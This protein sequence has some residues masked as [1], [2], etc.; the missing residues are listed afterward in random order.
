MSNVTHA[1]RSDSFQILPFI[2]T[3]SSGWFAIKIC[4]IC[5]GFGDCCCGQRGKIVVVFVGFS[6]CDFSTM[7]WAVD[8]IVFNACFAVADTLVKFI[9]YTGTSNGLESKTNS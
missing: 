8:A 3:E 2:L 1:G 4:G 5:S 6:C 9:S 7:L